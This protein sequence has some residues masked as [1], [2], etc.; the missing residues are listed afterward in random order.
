METRKA[1]RPTRLPY[2]SRCARAT[3]MLPPGLLRA[4]HYLCSRQPQEGG[5][6]GTQLGTYY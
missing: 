6:R 4:S 1:P 2:V 5:R 3:C